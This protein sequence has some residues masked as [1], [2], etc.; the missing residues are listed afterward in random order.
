MSQTDL[1]DLLARVREYCAQV[2][3]EEVP[4]DFRIVFRS[5]R[6]L[7]HPFPPPNQQRKPRGSP[8]SHSAD[9]RSVHW[10]GIDYTFSPTQAA[11][12][13]QLWQAWEDG[14]PEL[15]TATLLEGAGS[16]CERIPPLFQGNPAWGVMIVRG[17]GKGTFRLEP[18]G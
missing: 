7:Q 11:I 12:V 9:F 6:K 4:Q 8:Y 16:E 15:G 18:L 2:C 13:R 14:V 5:G 17:E 3:P 10:F 1:H